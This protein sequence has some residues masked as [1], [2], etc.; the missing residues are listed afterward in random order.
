LRDVEAAAPALG[1]QLKILN[2]STSGEIN[3]TFA[4]LERD[5]ADALFVAGDAF[6]FIRRAQMVNLASRYA[7]IAM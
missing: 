4:E 5:R 1:L 6:F 2:A 3:A 7:I